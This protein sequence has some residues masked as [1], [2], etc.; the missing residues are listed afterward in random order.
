MD[1]VAAAQTHLAHTTNISVRHLK[2]NG[3][4]AIDLRSHILIDQGLL[5]CSGQ[6][7]MQL[8]RSPSIHE[9]LGQSAIVRQ[10][11]K[12]AQKNSIAALWGN[13]TPRI[14]MA[15]S[16]PVLTSLHCLTELK[17]PLPRALPT[18]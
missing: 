18:S 15:Y 14:F 10:C 11:A 9:E 16:L 4:F 12:T 13:H 17:E 2:H 7:K 3:N 8:G 6:D 5:I 1:L